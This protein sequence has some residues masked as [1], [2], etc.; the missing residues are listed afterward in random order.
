MLAH[1]GF[2]RRIVRIPGILADVDGGFYAVQLENQRFCSLLKKTF[3]VEDPIVGQQ[4]LVVLTDDFTAVKDHC[5]VKFFSLPYNGRTDD[6]HRTGWEL[7]F[8]TMQLLFAVCTK[9]ILQ[10]QI[11]GWIARNDQ[12]RE[13]DQ[14]RSIAIGQA[15]FF[16]YPVGIVLQGPNRWIHLDQCGFHECFVILHP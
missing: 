12:F 15:G 2:D 4:H 3:F 6:H 14:L 8:Q 16:Q 13:N 9:V 11:F 5:G 1:K 10:D 7:F